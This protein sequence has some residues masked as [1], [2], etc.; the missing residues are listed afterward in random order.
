M[1]DGIRVEINGRGIR[2]I[3]SSADVADDLAR[4]AEDIA[5]ACNDESEWGG[6]FWAVST[7]GN[8]ARARVWNIKRG[9]SDDDTRDNRMIRSLDE[10]R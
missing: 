3:L 10:A 1:A 7:D 2:N 4:R 5:Q 9:Y 8:R 6:Y